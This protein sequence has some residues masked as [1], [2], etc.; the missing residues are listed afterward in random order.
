[1]RRVVEVCAGK[2]TLIVTL[3]PESEKILEQRGGEH[4]TGLAGLDERHKLN[5]KEIEMNEAVD[6]ALSY[7]NYFRLPNSKPKN[8]L[9]PLQDKTIK[10]VQ[11][12][13]GGVPRDILQTLF[14]IVEEGINARVAN[15]DLDFVKK[16]HRRIFDIVFDK[17]AEEKLKN[18]MKLVNP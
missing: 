4:L 2:A 13:R 6:I 10:Y 9:H 12:I 14:T 7:L 11:H 1:M 18:F 17:A 15:L 5:I 16:N 3:H 8:E